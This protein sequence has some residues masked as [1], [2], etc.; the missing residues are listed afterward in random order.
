MQLLALNEKMPNPY[1]I[2]GVE[3]NGKKR[4]SHHERI[5]AA[6]I[7]LWGRKAGDL[8]VGDRIWLYDNCDHEMYITQD[9]PVGIVDRTDKFVYVE[10]RGCNFEFILNLK[11]NTHVLLAPDD[12]E[13]DG[14]HT[15]REY[16]LD[17]ADE[18]GI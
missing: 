1:E 11:H 13:D 12:F 17:R 5:K 4:L 2:V 8:K 7:K 18:L 14:L 3:V 10:M 6:Q 15:K 16:W 9:D